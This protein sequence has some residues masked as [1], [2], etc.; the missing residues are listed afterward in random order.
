MYIYLSH[1]ISNIYRYIYVC[2][3]ELM[4]VF[5]NIYIYVIISIIN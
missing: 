4:G 2:I 3:L 5:E 1:T